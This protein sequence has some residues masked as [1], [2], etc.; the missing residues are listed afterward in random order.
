M[1]AAVEPE[2]V[3]AT[4]TRSVPSTKA[5]KTRLCWNFHSTIKM[6]KATA[7]PI[8]DSIISYFLESSKAWSFGS[9][10]VKPAGF[11]NLP[12]SSLPI[13]SLAILASITILRD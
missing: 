7:S 3:M 13:L 11:S 9:G 1:R 12:C 2:N 6:L 4:K 5:S 10:P 8:I